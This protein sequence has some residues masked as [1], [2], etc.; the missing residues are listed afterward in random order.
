MGK[1]RSHSLRERAVAR[2]TQAPRSH[3]GRKIVFARPQRGKNVSKVMGRKARRISAD[4]T[5]IG[6]RLSDLKAVAPRR[7]GSSTITVFR[8]PMAGRRPPTISNCAARRTT[9]TKPSDG[10]GHCSC[11]RPAASGELGLD[12]VP[13]LERAR[14]RRRTPDSQ[15][16]TSA[17]P[18]ENW[19]P[20]SDRSVIVQFL[21]RPACAVS[22]TR[23]TRHCDRSRN[24][25]AP[26]GP[27]PGPLPLRFFPGALR[28]SRDLR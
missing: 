17:G 25:R 23:R 11:G 1:H 19:P 5:A 18:W 27:T 13:L 15:S 14:D 22:S 3:H 16:S 28:P 21:G 20:C 7:R 8:S 2:A 4:A 26:R 10:S 24:D 12:R 9:P 6:A